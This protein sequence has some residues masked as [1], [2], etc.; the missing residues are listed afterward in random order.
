MKVKGGDG[1]GKRD[2]VWGGRGQGMPE[3]AWLCY[4]A[5]QEKGGHE[6]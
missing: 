4:R 1:M 2:Q 5:T 6:D 3:S